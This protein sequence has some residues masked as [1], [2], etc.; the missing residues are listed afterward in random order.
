ME[1]FVL[2][3]PVNNRIGEKHGDKLACPETKEE[4]TKEFWAQNV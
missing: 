1:D 3:T 2:C 4:V